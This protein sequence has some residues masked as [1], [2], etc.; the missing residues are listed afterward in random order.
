MTT[1]FGTINDET[2]HYTAADAERLVSAIRD[3][4]EAFEDVDSWL[5]DA[6]DRHDEAR[7]SAT[8]ARG[9][10]DEAI[11]HIESGDPRRAAEALVKARGCELEWGD[12]PCFREAFDAFD[13]VFGVDPTDH[14]DIG[15]DWFDPTEDQRGNALPTYLTHPGCPD[16][17][18]RIDGCDASAEVAYWGGSR[19]VG[20]G[21]QFAD[22]RHCSGSAFE[23]LAADEGY[24]VDFDDGGEE[25]YIDPKA[26]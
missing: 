13:E 22:W 19:Y 4:A 23:D 8:D 26:A 1:Y 17:I 7:E 24:T 3:A 11:D 21:R 10:A 20:T 14:R 9:Y 18:V 12:D 2:K 16:L 5:P 15:R 25:S 6:D